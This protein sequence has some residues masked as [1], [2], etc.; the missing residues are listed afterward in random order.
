M[1]IIVYPYYIFGISYIYIYHLPFDTCNGFGA[2]AMELRI[3]QGVVGDEHHGGHDQRGGHQTPLDLASRG[4]LLVVN[5][6]C[7]GLIMVV[8]GG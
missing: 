5:G 4:D 2:R 8:N 1:I 3:D 6:D 7:N